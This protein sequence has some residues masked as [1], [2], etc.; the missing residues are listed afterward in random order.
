MNKP[1]QIILNKETK[2]YD[3]DN[4]IRKIGLYKWDEGSIQ[5]YVWKILT[6]P[7]KGYLKRVMLF[8]IVIIN[9]RRCGNLLFLTFF[10]YLSSPSLI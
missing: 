8:I 7:N 4:K 3:W 10:L 5:N 2:L 9:Y 1:K 6:S